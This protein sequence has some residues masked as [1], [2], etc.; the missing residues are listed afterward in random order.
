MYWSHF[1]VINNS[2]IFGGGVNDWVNF[3]IARN[4]AR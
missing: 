4:W 1:A 2:P 3:R